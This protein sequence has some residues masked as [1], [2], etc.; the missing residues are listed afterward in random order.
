MTTNSSIDKEKFRPEY[1]LN[2]FQYTSL[3]EHYAYD[4]NNKLAYKKSKKL[5]LKF[6]RE[7]LEE[8][9]KRLE[10]EKQIRKG[11]LDR[12]TGEA[13]S[14]ENTQVRI[15][16]DI[17]GSWE[18]VSELEDGYNI[19]GAIKGITVGLDFMF[20]NMIGVGAEYQLKREITNDIGSLG[21]F[22]FTSV[23]GVGKLSIGKVYGVARAGYAL[24]SGDKAYSEGVDLKGGSMLG[25]G[26]GFKLNDNMSLEGE[27]CGYA[28][29]QSFEYY[30][31]TFVIDVTYVRVGTALVYSF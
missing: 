7:K 12:Y 13:Y 8:Q 20:N 5:M 28:G 1:A 11:A 21:K 27:F 3:Y 31:E 24:H 23:Y 15:V 10:K 17:T 26:V 30:G 29:T 18:G 16:A 6:Q 9:R 2:N 14:F 25:L 4:K 19:Y 22:G